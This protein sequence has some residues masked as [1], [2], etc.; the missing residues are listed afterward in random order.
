MT[1]DRLFVTSCGFRQREA[2]QTHRQTSEGRSRRRSVHYGEEGEEGEERRG[3]GLVV[4]EVSLWWEGQKRARGYHVSCRAEG[5]GLLWLQPSM[6]GPELEELTGINRA[7]IS[8][9]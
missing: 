9:Q 1:D 7:V 3:C 5:A 4:E 8:D 2:E 6:I